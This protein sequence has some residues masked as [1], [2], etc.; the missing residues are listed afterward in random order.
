MI[1][2]AF[3]N[4]RLIFGGGY[5]IFA[6][7][8]HLGL[9]HFSAGQDAPLTV[10][11]VSPSINAFKPQIGVRVMDASQNCQVVFSPNPIREILADT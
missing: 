2:F 4:F 9:T 11:C 1:I 6:K 10:D 5:A 3:V 8:L 7:C